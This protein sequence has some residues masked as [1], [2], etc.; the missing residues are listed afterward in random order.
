VSFA[1]ITLRIASQRVFIIV[2]VVVVVYFVIDSVRKLLD[3]PSYVLFQRKLGSSV[4]IG[5]RLR[6][7]R[8]VLN[9][10]QGQR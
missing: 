3:T 5:T 7:G 2:V 6:A 10:Q 9:S 8:P 4:S 1:A